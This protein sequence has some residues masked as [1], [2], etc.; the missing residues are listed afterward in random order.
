MTSLQDDIEARLAARAPDVEVL[1][2]IIGSKGSNRRRTTRPAIGATRTPAI[3][4]TRTQ[5]STGLV[6]SGTAIRIVLQR[7]EANGSS[8]GR[9]VQRRADD[10][11]QAVLPR[12]RSAQS[13]SSPG[14]ECWG[15]PCS[16]GSVARR[17][18]NGEESGTCAA[19]GCPYPYAA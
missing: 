13:D 17:S 16:P 10:C 6:A 15:D 14:G 18:A 11:A 3:A 9:D 7:P 8:G 1:L 12:Y 4:T 5:S 2:G 19:A